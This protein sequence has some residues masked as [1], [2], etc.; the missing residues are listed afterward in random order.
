MGLDCIDS[1]Y[2]VLNLLGEHPYPTN[3]NNTSTNSKDK[4]ENKKKEIKDIPSYDINGAT[5]I[6]KVD[7]KIKNVYPFLIRTQNKLEHV[8]KLDF[9]TDQKKTIVGTTQK[10]YIVNIFVDATGFIYES[11]HT[12]SYY[13]ESQ[14]NNDL[15]QVTRLTG[16]SVTNRIIERVSPYIIYNKDFND[17]DNKHFE[18]RSVNI[19]V[20]YRGEPFYDK[21]KT[22]SHE[23]RKTEN[24]SKKTDEQLEALKEEKAISIK[25][26][27]SNQISDNYFP[28]NH[29]WEHIKTDSKLMSAVNLYLGH[30]ITCGIRSLYFEY[31]NMLRE[32]GLFDTRKPFISKDNSTLTYT[33]S[34]ENYCTV[35]IDGICIDSETKALNISNIKKMDNVTPSRLCI[36]LKGSKFL[37]NDPNIYTDASEVDTNCSGEGE[38][39]IASGIIKN[40]ACACKI[41]QYF[42][43]PLNTF[44]MSGSRKSVDSDLIPIIL[45]CVRFMKNR[46]KKSIKTNTFVQIKNICE[47]NKLGT[48]Y[49]AAPHLD[50][51]K[52]INLFEL[53]GNEFVDGKFITPEY[54]QS[55]NKKFLES[56]FNVHVNKKK[57][58]K[59]SCVDSYDVTYLHMENLYESLNIK[60][61]GIPHFEFYFVILLLSRGSDFTVK[62]FNKSKIELQLT[63]LIQL[64][65]DERRPYYVYGECKIIEAIESDEEVNDIYVDTHLLRC[66]LIHLYFECVF[67]V[68]GILKRKYDCDINEPMDLFDSLARYDCG[69]LLF[70]D[71][72]CRNIAYIIRMWYMKSITSFYNCNFWTNCLDISLNNEF[73]LQFKNLISN[74]A[75]VPYELNNGYIKNELDD[76]LIRMAYVDMYPDGVFINGQSF[77]KGKSRK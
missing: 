74:V 12:K 30:S 65:N 15:I 31:V 48:S 52:I 63:K 32:K 21:V 72:C 42:D 13:N 73:D 24:K 71:T 38:I 55:T 2:R 77:I 18:R 76:T 70:M 35:Y 43:T 16:K 5:R 8:E 9:C 51:Y 28:N 11:L 56:K 54:Y 33:H 45:L 67:D 10:P 17:N 37:K 29:A 66:L 6:S 46:N 26:Y 58:T 34:D 25:Q 22:V 57:N 59:T 69:F 27:E 41:E 40:F 64:L 7:L 20:D 23:K 39:T 50:T 47:D 68:S 1:L 62:A 44:V 49:K 61:Q 53:N 14:N 75:K 3:D 4:V 19:V 60:F 36:E